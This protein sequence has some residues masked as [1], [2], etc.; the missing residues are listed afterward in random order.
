M[1]KIRLTKR[2]TAQVDDA[3]FADLNQYS[4]RAIKKE[5]TWYAI[6]TCTATKRT[7]RMHRQ[8]MGVL[9]EKSTEIDHI[10]GNGLNNQRSNLRPASRLQNS[11]NRARFCGS[12]SKYKGVFRREG[13]KGV[14]FTVAIAYN[15]KQKYLGT[16][17][18]EEEAAR[19]YNKA[20]EQLHGEFAKLNTIQDD[21]KKNFS[22]SQ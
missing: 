6:R 12:S 10:D 11:L 17:T 1:K 22:R 18:C 8:L 7:I 15:K 20:A 2:K 3:D 21:E 5:R 14:R 16:F 9:D 19:V 4:W 13:P